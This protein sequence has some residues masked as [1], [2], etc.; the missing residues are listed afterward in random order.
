MKSYQ[1]ARSD[2]ETASSLPDRAGFIIGLQVYSLLEQIY[3]RLGE[4]SLAD[5]YAQL[6]RETPPPVRKSDR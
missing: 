2:A 3:R 1:P 6:S 4:T 5:K